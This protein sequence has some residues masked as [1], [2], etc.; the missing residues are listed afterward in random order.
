M[1]PLVRL[2]R[3]GMTLIELLVGMTVTLLV[4]SAALLFLQQQAL[5]VSLGRD[6]MRVLQTYRFAFSTL[7]REVRTAGSGIIATQPTLVYASGDAVIFNA[8]YASNLLGDIHAVNI[9]TAL[10]ASAVSALRA[11]SRG[12]LVPGTGFSYPDTTYAG[13]YAETIAF[14][15][16]PDSTTP[17][18]DDFVLYR[19]VNTEQ[20]AVVARNV[21][22]PAAGQPF[23][24][25]LRLTTPPAGAAQLAEFPVAG[26]P[27]S[28]VPVHNSR[29]GARPDTGA[30]TTIDSVRAVRVSLTV[31]NGRSG[32]KEFRRSASALIRLDNA[33]IELAQ[34]CG[35]A[36][37]LSGAP[38][39]AAGQDVSTGQRYVQVSWSPAPDDG[40]GESDVLLYLLWRR[41]AGAG[42]WGEPIASV[43][44]GEASYLYRDFEVTEGASYQY[45]IAA[46]DCTP[47][48]SAPSATGVVTP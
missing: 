37:Q 35:E 36:P 45:A 47:N 38:S 30:A 40:G 43:A 34:L 33:G 46:R 13:S 9:D 2:D 31:T 42:D 16:R 22:R 28:H 21:M 10:E 26:L 7:R 8:D 3:R 23:F 6:Q 25:Y 41:P 24:A 14:Y 5:A 19:R 11:G 39:A 20:P 15:F 27:L 18:T 1:T 12:E 48:T 4:V 32:A 29:D 44:S 17:R